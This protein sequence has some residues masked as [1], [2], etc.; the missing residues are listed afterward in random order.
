MF[1]RDMGVAIPKIRLRVEQDALDRIQDMVARI[2][3]RC[4][5]PSP[6]PDDQSEIELHPSQLFFIL[7]AVIQEA[8]VD[9]QGNLKYITLSSR[10]V[11]LPPVQFKNQLWTS[12]TLTKTLIGLYGASF[13]VDIVSSL[14]ASSKQ[15][16]N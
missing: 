1:I 10:K 15:E 14:F 4:A 5:H 16:V 2:K 8:D 9:F 12:A 6:A 3:P 11:R 7:S 13:M